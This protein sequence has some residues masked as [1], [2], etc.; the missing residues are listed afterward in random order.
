MP[1]AF[2][3]FL[4]Y[5]VSLISFGLVSFIFI[6]FMYCQLII[7]YLLC[8][9][10]QTLASRMHSADPNFVE[11]LRRSLDPQNLSGQS[12]S[13]SDSNVTNDKPNDD[14]KKSE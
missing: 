14:E 13:Q 10:G 8:F 2:L 12:Q 4:R 11:N 3:L 5:V 6:I 7:I 9:R 1:G